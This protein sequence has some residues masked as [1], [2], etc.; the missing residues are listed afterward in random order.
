MFSSILEV[1]NFGHRKYQYN[2]STVIEGREGGRE[3]GRRE[4]GK[5][6]RE[7]GREEEHQATF[8]PPAYD[9]TLTH[10]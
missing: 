6:G 9:L 10:I 8:P 2:N 5:G 7:G 1:L 4:G 3:G